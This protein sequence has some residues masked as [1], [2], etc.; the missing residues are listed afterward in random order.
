MRSSSHLFRLLVR[1]RIRLKGGS[2]ISLASVFRGN[3]EATLHNL[4]E[5]VKVTVST[6]SNSEF[7]H[8]SEEKVHMEVSLGGLTA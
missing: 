3:A 4:V 8:G 5:M 7:V 6:A 1:L 2:G